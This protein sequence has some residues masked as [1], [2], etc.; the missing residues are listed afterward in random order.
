MGRDHAAMVIRPRHLHLLTLSPRSI[1]CL[2]AAMFEGF[3][4]SVGVTE[5]PG[6]YQRRCVGRA[7]LRRSRVGHVVIRWV[8]ARGEAARWRRNI[9][10]YRR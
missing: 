7:P 10:Q 9:C 4:H 2:E 8:P 3:D 6:G 5:P 1:P